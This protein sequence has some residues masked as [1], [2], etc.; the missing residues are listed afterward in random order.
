M[1][2]TSHE[3]Y[4]EDELLG[5]AKVL[6]ASIDFEILPDTEG[7]WRPVWALMC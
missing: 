7:A 1:K 3:G 5:A 6:D 2:W 4:N